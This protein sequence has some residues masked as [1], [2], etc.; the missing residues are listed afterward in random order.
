MKHAAERHSTSSVLRLIGGIR[1]HTPMPSRQSRSKS[2][3]TTPRPGGHSSQRL[4]RS[5]LHRQW[6]SRHVTL[7]CFTQ[8]IATSTRTSPKAVP[9][10]YI[11]TA[12]SPTEPILALRLELSPAPFTLS[13]RLPSTVTI[14]R[15]RRLP[16][17]RLLPCCRRPRT[18][19]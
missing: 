13:A 2:I 18:P 5:T 6:P 10:V 4:R 11:L 15:Q 17:R 7:L 16:L 1:K 12:R 14:A 3:A 19:Q 9:Q 8:H